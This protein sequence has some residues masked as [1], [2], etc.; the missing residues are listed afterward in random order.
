MGSVARNSSEVPSRSVLVVQCPVEHGRHRHS[1]HSAAPSCG[2][3]PPASS[4]WATSALVVAPA[5][6]CRTSCRRRR[7]T[8]RP[9]GC[10]PVVALVDEPR[11]QRRR[12]RGGNPARRLSSARRDRTTWP[13]PGP[14]R[15]ARPACRASSGSSATPRRR[16]SSTNVRMALTSPRWTAEGL[17]QGHDVVDVAVVDDGPGR[18]GHG[19]ARRAPGRPRN[20]ASSADHRAAGPP[21][22]PAGRCRASHHGVAGEHAGEQGE[23]VRSSRRRVVRAVATAPAAAGSR[24]SRWP[25]GRPPDR[26]R[27]LERGDPLRVVPQ[28]LPRHVIAPRGGATAVAA[29]SSVVGPPLEPPGLAAAR[30]RRRGSGPGRRSAGPALLDPGL[31][32][33]S[34]PAHWWSVSTGESSSRSASRRSSAARR[35]YSAAC[36]SIGTCVLPSTSHPRRSASPPLGVAG[37]RKGNS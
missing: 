20:D 11:H 37:R 33:V 29:A 28:H 8:G 9:P 23:P 25:A 1:D 2:S 16:A 15:G 5:C 10:G 30:R 19:L 12:E 4:S 18:L 6:R 22:R 31:V 27:C 24:W 32:H 14:R 35:R 26:V 36:G 3:S 17:G 21:P 34:G 13:A 7:T